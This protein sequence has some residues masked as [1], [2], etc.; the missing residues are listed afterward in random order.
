[1]LNSLSQER[2]NENTESIIM[3]FEDRIQGTGKLKDFQLKLHIDETV[4]PVAQTAHQIPFKMRK[5]VEKRSMNWKN[6][7]L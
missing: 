7:T 4:T 5:Q 3:S 2:A 6:A 1:M